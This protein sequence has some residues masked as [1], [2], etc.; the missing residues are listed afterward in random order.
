MDEKKTTLPPEAADLSD[1]A[2][3]E[4]SGGKLRNSAPHEKWKI[5]TCKNCSV[6]FPEHIFKN[7]NW[8]CPECGTDNTP[9]NSLIIEFP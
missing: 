3:D 7:Y 6:S 1:K 8:R 5:I 4:V 9:D 2:M